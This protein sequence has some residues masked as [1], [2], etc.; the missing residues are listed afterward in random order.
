MNDL[1]RAV[2]L[3]RDGTINVE[4]D[5]LHRIADFTFISGAPEAIR[6]LQEAG[7]LVIVV[8]NQSGVAR[9]YF[10]EAAVHALHE[11]IQQL[12]V[13]FGAAIDAFYH[14]PHHP[15]EGVGDY[16]VDCDCR[17]GSPGMLLQA[18]RE[19]DID[20]GRSFMIGDKLADIE[21]GYAAGCRSIPVRTGYGNTEEPKVTKQFP[22]TTV[23]NDLAT[24]VEYI[25]AQ[26]P[27]LNHQDTK[28]TKRN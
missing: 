5:Y 18:A 8:T 4:K 9:D 17:K 15:T 3:D 13:N 26:R 21:A 22:D 24:A 7:F 2:F 28:D 14:C 27:E 11:H 20:L 25:I 10:D 23:F 1:K 12:L 16:R 19:H 6:C